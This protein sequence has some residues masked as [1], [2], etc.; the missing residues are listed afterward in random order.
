MAMSSLPASDAVPPPARRALRGR[1]A[2]FGVSGLIGLTII[3]FWMFAAMVGPA[4][5]SRTGRNGG[6]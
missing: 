2:L 4:L 5:L 1:L 3:A 6:W